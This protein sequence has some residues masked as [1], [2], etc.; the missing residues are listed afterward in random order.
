MYT[1]PICAESDFEVNP[2]PAQ[3]G[4]FWDQTTMFELDQLCGPLVSGSSC[5]G[6]VGASPSRARAWG[7]VLEEINR[8][9]RNIAHQMNRTMRL[10]QCV[11]C[12]TSGPLR[13]VFRDWC[14]TCGP[15]K[16]VRLVPNGVDNSNH[17]VYNTSRAMACWE[18]PIACGPFQGGPHKAVRYIA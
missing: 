9:V 17:S 12:R 10:V 14:G 4:P 1:H 16:R 3:T 5:S 11:R 18:Q 2:F 13:V 8:V 7:L 15:T 6:P